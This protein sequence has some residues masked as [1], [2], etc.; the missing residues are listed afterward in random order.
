M[1]DTEL[2]KLYQTGKTQKVRDFAV[3]EMLRSKERYIHSVLS[4]RYPFLMKEEYHDE[5]M[6][7]CK[8]AVWE[9]LQTYDPSKKAS[10][11]TYCRLPIRHKI[12]S[13]AEKNVYK[14]SFYNYKKYGKVTFSNLDNSELF[15]SV[16]H[17]FEDNSIKRLDILN[18][19]DTLDNINK[20]I[21][22]QYY[23]NQW[24]L[25]EISEALE[26]S[27]HCVERRKATALKKLRMIIS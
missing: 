3:E 23:I 25:R 17:G 7:E 22:I 6:Q 27:L 16:E 4:R 13:F 2:I 12:H 11:L 15:L 8:I 26:L 24:S 21:L 14:N 18:L 1:T 9:Q 20:F 19:L 10:F 5:I